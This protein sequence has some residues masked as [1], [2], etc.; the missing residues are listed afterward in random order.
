MRRARIGVVGL[1]GI[2]ELGRGGLQWVPW[3]AE[4]SSLSASL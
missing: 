3:Y 1:W 2:L 4:C